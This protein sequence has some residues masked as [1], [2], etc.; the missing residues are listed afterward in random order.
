MRFRYFQFLAVLLS[1]G[2]VAHQSLAANPPLDKARDLAKTGDWEEV[3]ALAL[4]GT[5]LEPKNDEAWRLRGRA[6]L[7]FG[8]TTAAI[9]F[10]EQALA[11]NNKQADAVVDLTTVY[12]AMNRLT[13]ADRIVAAAEKKDPKG[14]IDEIKVSRALILGKQGKIGEA[15]PILASAT[16]KHPENPL[17]PLMLARI[18]NNANVTALA[19]DNYAKAW[20]LDEGNPDIAFEYGQTLLTLKEYDEADKLFKIVQ[21]RDPDNKQVDYLRGRLR[22]A[23]KRFAEAS[24][25][26][27]KAVD[28]DPDNFLANYWLG[29]SFV[30]LSKAEKK[31]F[32]AAAMAPLRKAL[33]LRPERADISLSLAEAEYFVGRS[34]FFTSQQDSISEDSRLRLADEFKK[35]AE[36]YEAMAR[37]VKP[38]VPP[39]PPVPVVDP[40]G[41]V[42]PIPEPPVLTEAEYSAQMLALASRYRSAEI[43]LRDR[44]AKLDGKHPLRTE[45]LELSA[46]TMLQA[47][48][49][50]PE[51]AKQQDVYASIARAFDKLEK[52]DS[53][54]T[55]TDK[56]LEITPSSSSDITRKV[57]LLQRINDQARL[58]DY[59]EVIISAAPSEEQGLAKIAG[60]RDNGNKNTESFRIS[61]KEWTIRWVTSPLSVGGTSVAMPFSF[62]IHRADGELVD[63]AANIIGSDT[64]STVIRE[65]GEFYLAI[66]SSQPYTIDVFTKKPS[67]LEQYGLILVN[68]CIETKQDERA[69]ANVQKVIARDPS[70]CD[71]HQL[72]AYIDLKRERYN[73]AIS[74]LLEGVKACP[75][76]SDLWVFLGDSY[77]FS[78]EN[79]KPTVQR[80]K[81]AYCRAGSLGNAVGREKCEQ[82]GLILQQMRK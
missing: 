16:A 13:D 21:E 49:S 20:S 31:N 61:K 73:A 58:A 48:N 2:L 12:V 1:F 26:F 71:A 76:N 64:G 78:N 40:N 46:A 44:A 10:Y 33:A 74:A 19:K 47:V 32:Y 36:S 9:G 66:N 28:K 25:E 15:T 52:F 59:L 67:M 81:D 34:T 35:Q 39:K 68:A 63:L 8:D 53:A 75:N 65:S 29:R 57:S 54:L 6:E 30:D 77:Y 56:Q 7:F 45:L 27:Q 18:Y 22:F 4:E 24:A 14:K 37:D 79:D 55:Y 23:A 17:Y 80:A 70:N 82:I 60:W 62:T 50:A 5:N 3:Q 41:G 51:L 11:L 43:S 38:P 69:R 72:N 42:P